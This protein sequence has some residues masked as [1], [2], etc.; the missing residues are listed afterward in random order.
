M[1]ESLADF[2]V[3]KN[4]NLLKLSVKLHAMRLKERSLEPQSGP[5]VLQGPARPRPQQQPQLPLPGKE[6]AKA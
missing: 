3:R 4:P 5:I 1:V 6:P 2:L